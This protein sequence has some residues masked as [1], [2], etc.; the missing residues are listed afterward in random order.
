MWLDALLL[1]ALA[2]YAGVGA[3][4]GPVESALRLSAW[5]AGYAAAWLA[6]RALGAPLAHVLG[7]A[8]LLGFPLA[9]TTA[10]L[11]TQVA[12]LLAILRTRRDGSPPAFAGRAVGAALGAARGAVIVVLLGW[13][14][15]LGEGLR[16]QGVVALPA[17][18]DSTLGRASESL[19]ER[20]TELALGAGRPEARAVA[21]LVARPA[22]TAAAWR[23][24]LAHPRF[25]AVQSDTGFWRAVEAGDLAGARGAASFRA[26]VAD[27]SVRAELGRLGLVSP[28]A[29]A[30][31]I[32]FERELSAALGSAASRVAT[33]RDD[34]EVQALLADPDVRELLERG[35][36]LR[37][38]AHPGFQTL[39]RRAG[40]S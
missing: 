9:G 11:A 28:A 20:G 30:Y 32:A 34:P 23:D 13:L 8:P 5:I 25:A 7:I 18:G 26:L 10:F 24:L 36:A 37:L 3:W 39:L 38:L 12:F 19:V 40:A 4:R 29:A 21:A 22:E 14:A 27:V 17:L 1:G 15:T 31:P 33:L 6:A 2:A 35:D 16:A